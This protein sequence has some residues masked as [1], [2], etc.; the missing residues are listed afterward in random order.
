MPTEDRTRLLIVEDQSTIREMLVA[1]LTGLPEFEVV[2]EAATFAEAWEQ[3]NRC[4]PDVVVLDWVF[5][6]G[7][8]SAFLAAMRHDRLRCRVLVLTGNTSEELVKEALSAGARG[9]FEKGGNLQEFFRALRTVASGGAFFGPTV[10]DIVKHL[11]ETQGEANTEAP[12]ASGA[13]EAAAEMDRAEP[14]ARLADAS[15][16]N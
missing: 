2:G 4:R 7:G 10:S 9:V 1:V 16:V 14:T 15:A 3:V 5:P 11:I 12:E 8:G 13:D 6:G